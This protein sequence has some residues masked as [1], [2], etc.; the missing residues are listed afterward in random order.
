M[1]QR[2]EPSQITSGKLGHYPGDAAEDREDLDIAL[3]DLAALPAHAHRDLVAAVRRRR[4]G[5]RA[6]DGVEDLRRGGQDVVGTEVAIHA[7]F[8]PR[9]TEC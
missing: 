1:R 4:V 3:E 6:H 8:I 2:T 7:G 5:V 9:R